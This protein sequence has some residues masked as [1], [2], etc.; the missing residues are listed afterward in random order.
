MLI[1]GGLFY[2]LLLRGPPYMYHSLIGTVSSIVL[3]M[4][5]KKR[6]LFTVAYSY[7]HV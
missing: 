5:P 7:R 6:H 1:L 4:Q 2:V 3:H